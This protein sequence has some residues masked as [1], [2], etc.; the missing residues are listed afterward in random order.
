MDALA[1]ENLDLRYTVRKPLQ[2]RAGIELYYEQY[3]EGSALTIVNN[4][5]VISPLWRNFTRY[6]AKR[7]CITTYDLRNQG[8]SSLAE[9]EV[10][11]DDHLED[12]ACLLE[13]LGRQKTWLLGT[14]TST[15]ICR[16]FALLHPERVQGL[17]LVGPLFC[18]Y[19][20][21]RRKL[22]TKSWLASL[23][24][25]GLKGLFAHIYP[26]V[27]SDRTIETG[28]SPGYLAL[29]ERFLALNSVEQVRANL[30]ASL[31]TDDDPN[32]L[33]Q[34]AC[35][36]LLLAGEADFLT[37]P[38][39]LEAACKLLPRGELELL[40]FAGHVP[41]FEATEAFEQAVHA[42]IARHGERT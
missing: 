35:P 16:D 24:H 41:Y 14:S 34:L 33:R 17:V 8:A 38:S 3:G 37:C 27:Y 20:S 15:L 32:K 18:P 4:F 30:Q 7:H 6:L 39:S 21:R 42:F 2:G 9:K 12:L 19:G 31:T 23:E 13:Q 1:I 29:R 25:G 40:P 5:F 36:T 10:R 26:L 22:L 28:G 11:F